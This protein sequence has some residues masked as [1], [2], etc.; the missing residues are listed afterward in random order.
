MKQ[1][2]KAGSTSSACYL[3]YV[4]FFLSFL[5]SLEDGGDTFLRNED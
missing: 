2:K 5:F 3:L 1:V 4:D